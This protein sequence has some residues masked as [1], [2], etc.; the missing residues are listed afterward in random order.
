MKT[1]K[2]LKKKVTRLERKIKVKVLSMRLQRNLRR[3]GFSQQLPQEREKNVI[4]RLALFFGLGL[5]V[6]KLRK[7]SGMVLELF[8]ML[9]SHLLRRGGTAHEP[10]I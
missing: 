3:L 9:S 10:K 7:R 5:A 2:K 6:I 8:L 1:A 4:P